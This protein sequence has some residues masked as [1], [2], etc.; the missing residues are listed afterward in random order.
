MTFQEIKLLVGYKMEVFKEVFWAKKDGKA[1]ESR[2][3]KIQ[4]TLDNF[5]K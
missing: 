5:A 2:L 1:L 3:D 4:T